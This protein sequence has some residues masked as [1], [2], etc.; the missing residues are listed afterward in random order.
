MKNREQCPNRI[1]ILLIAYK[2]G[3][4]IYDN[5]NAL[6]ELPFSRPKNSL[7]IGI[8]FYTFMVISYVVDVYKN[9]L[10]AQR[11]PL[12]FLMFISLFQHL[13]AGPIVRYKH[14]SDQIN[15]RTI[16]WDLFSS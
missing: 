16:N 13:V 10:K 11:N 6:I 12:N 7:P 5:L 8:S 4:F 3:G 9:E 15:S 2:Y 14:I 1:I